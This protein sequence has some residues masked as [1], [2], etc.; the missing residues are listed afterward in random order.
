MA[1]EY[2]DGPVRLTQSSLALCKE[3]GLSLVTSEV[4]SGPMD[5]SMESSG[6]S[7]LVH[8]KGCLRGVRSP[9]LTNA[10]TVTTLRSLEGT[11]FCHPQISHLMHLWEWISSVTLIDLLVP[12]HQALCGFCTV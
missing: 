11:P 8:A 3:K 2:K 5:G 1:D 7:Q 12:R 4:G 10:Q 9:A 6:E